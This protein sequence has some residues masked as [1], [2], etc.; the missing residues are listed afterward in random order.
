MTQAAR[1]KNEIG[2]RTNKQ[3]R[4]ESKQGF[5]GKER[6][7]SLLQALVR[8]LQYPT[9]ILTRSKGEEKMRC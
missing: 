2:I 5:D 6:G 7:S 8:G 4:E 1:T 9:L 3:T